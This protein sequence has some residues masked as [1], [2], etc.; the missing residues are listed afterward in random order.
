[1]EVGE[2]AI[3]TV[4]DL[5]VELRQADLAFEADRASAGEELPAGV[6]DSLPLLIGR[7]RP[8]EGLEC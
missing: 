3:R 7:L 8:R 2:I 1:M 5:V 4:V 6:G